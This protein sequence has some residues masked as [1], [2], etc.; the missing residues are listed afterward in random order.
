MDGTEQIDMEVEESDISGNSNNDENDHKK[1]GSNSSAKRL[2][3]IIGQPPDLH[4]K[5]Q[6]CPFAPRCNNTFTQCLKENPSLINRGKNHKVACWWNP[7]TA[8]K[9]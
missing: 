2:E 9:V 8:E 4:Q 1:S 5:P 7:D 6:S 3:S